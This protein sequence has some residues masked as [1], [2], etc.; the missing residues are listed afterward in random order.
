MASNRN[1]L[2]A[3]L[4]AS[5]CILALASCFDDKGNYDYRNIN[6]VTVTGIE[7]IYNIMS[8]DR[9]TIR[10]EIS[11]TND[12]GYTEGDYAYEWARAYKPK[13]GELVVIST[14]KYLEDFIFPMPAGN[15]VVYYRV[16]DK[17]T[18]LQWT[19]EE[20]E[21]NI[22]GAIGPG[23][24]FMTETGGT[25]GLHHLNYFDYEFELKHAN[26]DVLPPLGDPIGVVCYPDRNSPKL[27]S[28]DEDLIPEAVCVM[29]TNGTYKL[30]PVD[31]SYA[32]EYE[33]D[34]WFIARGEKPE[35]Q[36]Y[37]KIIPAYNKYEG[38]AM[39]LTNDGNV[40]YYSRQGSYSVYPNFTSYV[41][42]DEREGVLPVSDAIGSAARSESG[43]IFFTKDTK[44]FYYHI[45]KGNIMSKYDVGME[46]RFKFNNTGSELL[47]IQSREHENSAK[48][49]VY[50]LMRTGDGE[51]R[52]A[53]FLHAGGE[54][55]A[56]LDLSGCPEIDSAVD[57][58]M[59]QG[60]SANNEFFYYRTSQKIYVYNTAY[61][62][63]S[64]VYEAPS[65]SSITYT[66]FLSFP[67]LLTMRPTDKEGNTPF[68]GSMAVFIC[69]DTNPES[70]GTVMLKSIT[71]ATG[72]LTDTKY[73][74][75]AGNSVKVE[76]SGFGRVISAD[77]KSQ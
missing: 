55:A 23:L 61:E 14:D 71:A 69:E 44:T 10:P 45:E 30:N 31:F 64:L 40:L 12:S 54:Q 66:R 50:A 62:T 29:G 22:S 42:Y 53:S 26:I 9:V 16:T 19:S 18:G 8:G 7:K 63:T 25:V 3:V 73:V 11:G 17:K 48:N 20:F 21:V 5:F 33:Y 39:I 1:I 36:Y 51:T 43:G 4:G 2:K 6:E 75:S 41:N 38:E 70:G 58:M 28:G 46:T 32:P 37:K 60:G 47:W 24:F 49:K 68:I 77:W 57:Y 52:L 76:M 72:A 15:H 35:G 56:Y 74:N 65:E 13:D 27:Y 67:S 34:F 59:P